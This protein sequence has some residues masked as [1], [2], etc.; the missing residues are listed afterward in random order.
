MCV[1]KAN[2][3]CQED[4]Y[5]QHFEDGFVSRVER[6][7]GREGLGRFKWLCGP[8]ASFCV[9]GHGGSYYPVLAIT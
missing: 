7:V 5:N 1:K 8:V 4:E 2:I 9:H 3:M 6:G